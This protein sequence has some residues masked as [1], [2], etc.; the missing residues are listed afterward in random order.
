MKRK[1]KD[2]IIKSIL[3]FCALSSLVFLGGIVVVL[4]S[5][6]LNST[7]WSQAL[8]EKGKSWKYLVE[9][10]AIVQEHPNVKEEY[11]DRAFVY[12]GS[13]SENAGGQEI[14]IPQV[15]YIDSNDIP[16]LKPKYHPPK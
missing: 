6:F 9:R 11:I 13:G 7:I 10:K 5:V 16:L 15:V 12:Y 2:Y 3:L 1:T 8:E 4:F 14:G